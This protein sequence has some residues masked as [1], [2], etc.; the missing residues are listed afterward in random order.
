MAEQPILAAGGIVVRGN[1]RPTIA[2]VQLRKGDWVLPKGKLNRGEDALAAAQREV[3]EETGQT[4]TVKEFLG[5]LCYEVN[6]RQKIVQFWRMHPNGGPARE[7][8][9]DI[10]QV[11]WLPLEKAIRKLAR[12]HEKAFLASAGP[13]AIKSHRETT[14]IRMLPPAAPPEPAAIAAAVSLAAIAADRTVTSQ[15]NV[16]ARALRWLRRNKV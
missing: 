5:T 8:M 6:G 13:V 10:R 1:T 7:L 9:R 2:V 15:R 16:V 11:A 14:A 4:V 3:H 12:P